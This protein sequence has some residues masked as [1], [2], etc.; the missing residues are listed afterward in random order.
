MQDV[1]PASIGCCTSEGPISKLSSNALFRKGL[2]FPSVKI[3]TLQKNSTFNL[4]AYYVDENELPPGT[5]TN[6]GSFQVCC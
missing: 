3:I 5:A 6:I 4:D 1:I 2:P